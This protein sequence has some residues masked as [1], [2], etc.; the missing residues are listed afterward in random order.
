M[1]KGAMPPTRDATELWVVLQHLAAMSAATIKKE[2]S[3]YFYQY[4]YCQFYKEGEFSPRLL[5]SWL[6]TYCA[7]LQEIGGAG[8]KVLD[9]G[10]GPGF[11][12]LAYYYAGASQVT[13]IDNHVGSIVGFETMDVRSAQAS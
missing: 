5:E 10:C 4:L 2:Y 12:L 1:A 8:R 11:S 3:S 13:G 7:T 6:R 9:V